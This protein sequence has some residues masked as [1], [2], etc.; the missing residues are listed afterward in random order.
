MPTTDALRVFAAGRVVVDGLGRVARDIGIPKSSLKYFLEGASPRRPTT[1]KLEDW[2]L[3][4]TAGDGDPDAGAEATAIA[5]LLRDLPEPLRAQA[6]RR[7]LLLWG[8]FFDSA[9]LPRPLWLR[10]LEK[11]S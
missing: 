4:T 8:E 6:R 1:R 3:R 11:N 9:R 10:Q 2:Y 7:V 5:V